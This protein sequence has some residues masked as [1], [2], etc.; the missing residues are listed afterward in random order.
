MLKINT[1]LSA[2]RLVNTQWHVAEMVV[3]AL[4]IAADHWHCGTT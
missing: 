2:A 4:F 3:Q 1:T